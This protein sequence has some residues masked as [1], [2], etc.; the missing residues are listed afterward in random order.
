[1][2][3]LQESRVESFCSPNEEKNGFA[4][5]AGEATDLVHVTQ[6]HSSYEHTHTLAT[7]QAWPSSRSVD[8]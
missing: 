3:S 6:E 2:L 8:D 4:A 7:L 1:M 5:A